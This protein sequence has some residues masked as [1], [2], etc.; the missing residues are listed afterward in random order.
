LVLVA[1]AAL[2]AVALRHVRV[3]A[4]ADAESDVAPAAGP[5][6]GPYGTGAEPGTAPDEARPEPVA[7]R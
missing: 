4:D 3:E 5:T 7:S 2:A 1:A 6:D